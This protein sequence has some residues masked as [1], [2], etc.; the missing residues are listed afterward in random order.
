MN[1]FNANSF[2]SRKKFNDY[3]DLSEEFRII[4]KVN[5]ILYKKGNLIM[6][7]KGNINHGFLG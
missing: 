7:K 5:I 1:I 2:L 3:M 4:V 6:Y